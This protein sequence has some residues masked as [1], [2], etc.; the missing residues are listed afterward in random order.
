M[1]TQKDLDIINAYLLKY[2][3]RGY[4]A[5]NTETVRLVEKL[6]FLGALN[7]EGLFDE[8]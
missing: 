4:C 7:L 2:F 5:I 3:D 8:K 6:Y 1:R